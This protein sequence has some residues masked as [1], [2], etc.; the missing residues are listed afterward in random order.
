MGFRVLAFQSVENFYL[1]H[2]ALSTPHPASSYLL[3]TVPQNRG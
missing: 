2:A 3:K 1:K